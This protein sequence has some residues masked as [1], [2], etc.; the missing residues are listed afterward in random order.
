MLLQSY[1][2]SCV[3]INK[4]RNYVCT[5]VVRFSPFLS[6]V[7][8]HFR[9]LCPLGRDVQLQSYIKHTLSGFNFPL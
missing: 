7:Q 1:Y 9:E 6:R 3:S 4:Q 2:V 5:Y 8:Y